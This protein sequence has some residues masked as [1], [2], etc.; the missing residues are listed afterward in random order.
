MYHN[1]DDSKLK[2]DCYCVIS[3][4]LLQEKT[5]VHCFISLVIPIICTGNPRIHRIKYFN[6]GAASQ[7][8]IFKSLITLVYHEHDFN[9][10]AKHHFFATSH[11]KK[12]C[13]GADGTIK[14]EAANASLRAA[15]TNQ[16]L[17]SEQ[18]FLWAKE[19]INGVT[20]YYVTEEDIISHE[21]KYDLKVRYNG[22]QT[23][24]GICSYHCF[25]PDGD[26]LIMKRIS[27][28]TINDVHKFN[29][30]KLLRN[31]TIYQPG[32]YIACY[33]D[34]IWYIGVILECSNENQ[35]VKIKFMI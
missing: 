2:C 13:N 32:K 35:A 11:G 7:Y 23:V 29:D 8:K 4:H 27:S 33:Y 30:P 34:K 9:L 3:D 10:K 15:V 5:A 19:N 14:R 17:T 21:R 22:V 24:P 26:S 20:M 12:Q 25:I 28:D 16:I 6:D 1:D 31:P 18:L